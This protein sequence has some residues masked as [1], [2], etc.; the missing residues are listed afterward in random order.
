MNSKIKTLQRGFTLIELMI[1]VAIIGILAAIAIPQY[2]DYVTR[3]RWSDNISRVGQLK[4]AIAECAQNNNGL[5]TGAPCTVIGAAGDAAG[6][7]LIGG[8]FLPTNYVTPTAG[9]NT[10]PYLRA[11]VT[12]TAATGAIVLQGNAQTAAG[13]D[14]TMT[15]NLPAGATAITWDYTVAGA[16]GCNRSKTGVGPR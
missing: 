16:A 12:V 7:S 15:P 3:A 8:G 11:V 6:A 4:Q 2:Q 1:V 10:G 5:L 14:V 9:A 13:C